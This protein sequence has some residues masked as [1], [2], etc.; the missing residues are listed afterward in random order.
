ML[1]NNI[2]ALT[3]D[4]G[5]TILDWHSGFSF[6]FETLKSKYNFDYHSAHMANEMRQKSLSFVTN[7]KDESPMNFDKAHQ[8]AINKINIEYELGL[9]KEDIFFMYYEIPSKLKTW[10][11]F[12]GPF[13]FLKEKYLCVS[14]TLLSNR[15]V[16]INSKSNN[17]NWDLILS[18]ETLE[19]YKPKIEAY[20]KTAKLL[21]L[22]PSECCMVACHSFDLNAAKMAG[23]KTIFI[24]RAME[25]GK[26]TKINVDGEY[27]LVLDSFKNLKEIL[28]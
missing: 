13:N 4:T 17:I 8:K 7:Q 23:F 26:N 2:K 11:D 28:Y 10:S 25:W 19:V 6:G 16:F 5:G 12:L 20:T 14:F 1:K 21:Q 15:L 18:C 27:D 24:K 9:N 22:D 3:F